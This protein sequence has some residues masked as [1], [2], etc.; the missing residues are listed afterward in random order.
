[1]NDENRRDFAAFREKVLDDPG[2]AREMNEPMDHE[3]YMA[4]VVERGRELGFEFTLAEVRAARGA[5][6]M[7]FLTQWNPGQ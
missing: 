1:M 4:R 2:L 6:H 3:P 5:G 7:A